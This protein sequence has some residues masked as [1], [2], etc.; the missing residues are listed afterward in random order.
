MSAP[1]CSATVRR[2][3]LHTV[4]LVVPHLPPGASVVDVGC[5]EG[6]VAEEL[7]RRGVGE[8]ALV[9]VVDVRRTRA[10]PFSFYD[11]VNLPF[12]DGRFDV[13]MLN[14]VLHHVPNDRKVALLREAL[15][16]ARQ[17][18]FILEDTPATSLD[19]FVSRRHGESY[20]R[21][22]ASHAPFGFLSRN[23][24][25]WLFR[26]M[27]VEAECRP[28]GRFCRS[29]LQPFARSSFVLHKVSAAQPVR[30]PVVQNSTPA[31]DDSSPLRRAAG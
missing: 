2:E 16:V 1:E 26:G 4:S 24:W 27:G 12:P 3:T 8:L 11:G 21:K 19:R 10:L 17:T 7:L 15:R 5:G 23:E 14:F 9:D 30:R 25:A 18:V 6:W 28:L 13:A 29:V 20:R 31:G 22:I